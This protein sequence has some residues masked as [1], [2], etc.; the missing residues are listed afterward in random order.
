[1][2]VDAGMIS[3]RD[4]ITIATARDDGKRLKRPGLQMV[5]N[6]SDHFSSRSVGFLMGG[7]SHGLQVRIVT[8]CVIENKRVQAHMGLCSHALMP[9][10][11]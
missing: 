2:R 1:M 11:P 3:T 4:A 9:H 10:T 5:A 6:V 7:Q 8:V